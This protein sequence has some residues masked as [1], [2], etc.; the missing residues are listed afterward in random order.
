[1]TPVRLA[2]R[3]SL[4]PV[5]VIVAAGAFVLSSPPAAARSCDAAT[6][7]V[8]QTAAPSQLAVTLPAAFQAATAGDVSVTQGGRTLR[9]VQWHPV[10][11][12]LTDVV[13]VAD[14]SARSAAL[15]PARAAAVEG[16]LSALPRSTH[17]GLVAAGSTAL[18]VQPLVAGP[19]AARKAAAGLGSGGGG[20]IIDAVELANIMLPPGSGRHQH[21]VVVASGRDE[22]QTPW[23]EVGDLLSRRGI[24][25]DVLDL[26]AQRAIPGAGAQ[27]PTS[28]VAAQPLADGHE[29]GA[30]IA[31]QHLLVV[32]GRVDATAVL[33]VRQGDR[34]VA[35]KVSLPRQ[36]S[37]LGRATLRQAPSSGVGVGTLFG[38]F[39]IGL[40]VLLFCLGGLALRNPQAKVVRAAAADVREASRAVR[41]DPSP[42]GSPQRAE[43]ARRLA[44]SRQDLKAA[45]GEAP[46][47]RALAEESAYL[48]DAQRESERQAQA[49]AE[50]RVRARDRAAE[51][52]DRARRHAVE[53]MAV[54]RANQERLELLRS[55]GER[56]VPTRDL[57]DGAAPPRTGYSLSA[58][59]EQVEAENLRA[60]AA[61]EAAEALARAQD[62]E[63]AAELATAERRKA[64]EDAREAE[65]AAAREAKA[66][67][68]AMRSRVR[69]ERAAATAAAAAETERRKAAEAER[70]RRVAQARAAELKR[71]RSRKTAAKKARSSPLVSPAGPQG[72]VDAASVQAADEQVIDLRPAVAPDQA[73]TPPRRPGRTGH[74]S[75][76]P[77][78]TGSGSR[79]G[80]TR[81]GRQDAL[82]EA[83]LR[84]VSAT[85]PDVD[86]PAVEKLRLVQD[87]SEVAVVEDVAATPRGP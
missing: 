28:P 22:S 2:R 9:T 53:L 47:A 87:A 30:A 80:P 45:L 29:V 26:S 74:A 75:Q 57:A 73:T 68:T 42:P 23:A 84:Q 86:V 16:V 55:A 34:Q 72:P 46:T 14:V 64:E 41:H 27:C 12:R 18:P 77:C 10:D 60:E 32:D 21:I 44:D 38:A 82:R 11:P 54:E 51:R 52:R 1:M 19:S 78:R 50:E 70:R 49:T 15:A 39:G 61:R 36:G 37:P 8:T 79:A 13:V 24:A 17:V 25:L 40:F 65:E 66:M 43:A 63:A 4:L 6:A 85:V 67:D 5:L 76:G 58:Y 20:A 71:S 35:A 69:A 48:E 3:A 33:T 81:P 56:A 7:L 31:S 59:H 83:R 62:A